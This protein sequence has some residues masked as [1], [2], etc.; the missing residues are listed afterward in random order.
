VYG[1]RVPDH[2]L[3]DSQLPPDA[4]IVYGL[5]AASGPSFNPSI[6]QIKATLGMGQER[7]YTA[8]DELEKRDLVTATKPSEKERRRRYTEPTRYTVRNGAGLDV[9][10]RPNRVRS[11]VEAREKKSRVLALL[12]HVY[13]RRAVDRGEA[14]PSISQ[15][16]R[17][18]GVSARRVERARAVLARF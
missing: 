9:W 15:T 7:I 5:L 11:L 17:D 6:R 14:R 12:L 16:A 10:I 3:L 1:L 18:L 2:V 8:L 13:E 4:K